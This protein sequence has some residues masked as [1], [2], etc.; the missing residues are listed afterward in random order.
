VTDAKQIKQLLLE[1]VA[2]LA[3]Y[4]F[5][6]GKKKGNHWHVGSIEGEAGESFDIC[7]AGEKAGLYGD[8]ADSEKHSRN[9]LELW[10]G[11]RHLDF[12][13]ALHEAAKWLGVPLSTSKTFPTLSDAISAAISMIRNQKKR[14]ML[15][16]R[17]DWYH[18]RNGKE[19][20]VVVRFDGK[21]CKDFRPFY[22]TADGWV[23]GD[24][25]GKLPLFDLPKLVRPDLNRES[26]SEPVFVPEGEKCVC[27]LR[28]KLGLLAT[29]SSHGAESP[30]KS[31][32]E[33][34]AARNVVILADNDSP[35]QEYA[36]KVA[37]LLL[38]LS[39]QPKVKIVELPELPPAGD[40]VQ[41]IAARNGKP[42]RRDQGRVA[43]PNKKCGSNPPS[44]SRACR[45]APAPANA[46]AVALCFAA[47]GSLS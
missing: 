19:H 31:D 21:E 33:P 38:Q 11:A 25:P 39:P 23:I 1:H 8:F 44:R 35:G 22:Q 40:C 14:S 46:V 28:D 7:I 6:K 9:L 36:Q 42:P 4:L 43:C 34:L 18:D 41:W 12:K 45:A 47:A 3:P 27:E 2:D 32:W 5:P 10:M 16:G 13:T 37:A 26:S 24:P 20:F 17:R 15:V 30:H 29:T